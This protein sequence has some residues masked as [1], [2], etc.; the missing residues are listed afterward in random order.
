MWKNEGILFPA[1]R[2]ST[3][4]KKRYATNVGINRPWGTKPTVQRTKQ[5]PRLKLKSKL[6][7]SLRGS[8]RGNRFGCHLQINY[9]L[10]RLV[11]NYSEHTRLMVIEVSCISDRKCECTP[12]PATASVARRSL[13]RFATYRHL[14]SP[15][16]VSTARRFDRETR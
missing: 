10:P 8:A 11:R 14:V 3:R 9:P 12:P 15:S 5:K 1:G 2:T 4:E 13:D 6:E 7:T 16:S